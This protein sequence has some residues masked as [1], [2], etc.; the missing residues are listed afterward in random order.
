[1]LIEIKMANT[2]EI[3]ESEKLSLDLEM[4]DFMKLLEDLE[5]YQNKGGQHNV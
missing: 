3:S 2:V 5:I 4:L 1:M